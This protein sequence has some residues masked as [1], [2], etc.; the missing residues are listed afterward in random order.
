MTLGQ[1]SGVLYHVICK[2]MIQRKQNEKMKK[3][4]SK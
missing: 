3:M 4:C 1:K 2:M